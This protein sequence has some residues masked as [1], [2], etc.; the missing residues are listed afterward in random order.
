[1]LLKLIQIYCDFKRQLKQIRCTNSLF[2]AAEISKERKRGWDKEA[3]L[4]YKSTQGSPLLK[5]TEALPW[6]S[7]QN[8]SVPSSTDHCRGQSSHLVRRDR[9]LVHIQQNNRTKGAGWASVQTCRKATSG[10]DNAF[11]LSGCQLARLSYYLQS[12]F[13]LPLIC[14]DHI[15]KWITTTLSFFLLPLIVLL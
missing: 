10:L 1:M 14:F 9:H 13:I 12:V 4:S 15:I 8:F 2:I 11:L 5:P 3:L 6:K 7:H